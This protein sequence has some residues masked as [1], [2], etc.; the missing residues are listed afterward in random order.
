MHLRLY[1]LLQQQPALFQDFSVDVRA[2]LAGL[3]IYGLI[4][5]FDPDG[6]SRCAHVPE[7]VWRGHSC[8]RNLTRTPNQILPLLFV[9]PTRSEAKG[10]EAA[11]RAT[12]GT[13][14]VYQ[15]PQK[16][17]PTQFSPILR[18]P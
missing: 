14:L 9:I 16:A 3:R 8:P 18:L 1:P 4:F 10:E 13:P 15:R 7:L 5:L 12:A 11:V 2:Q 6:E 17:G